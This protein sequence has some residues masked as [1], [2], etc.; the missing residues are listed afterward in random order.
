MISV[1]DERTEQVNEEEKRSERS[2][3]VT[4]PVITKDST[5]QDEKTAIIVADEPAKQE[6]CQAGDE[7]DEEDEEH[8]KHQ[9]LQR[10]DPDDTILP[11][12]VQ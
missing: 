11:L 5:E 2:A 10:V 9:P 3:E 12:S 7:E 6:H 8:Q 1:L 4:I